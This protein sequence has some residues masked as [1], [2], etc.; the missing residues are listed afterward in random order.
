MSLV[1]LFDTLAFDGWNPLSIF[2]T[3]AASGADAWLASDTSAFA[4]TQIETRETPDAYVFSARLPPGVAKEELSIK[5]EVDEDGAGNGNVLVI[6]GERSVRREAVRG[7][8]RRQ[9]VIERSRATFFGRFHLPEDA[10]VDRVRAA[11]D[12][13]AGALLT[14]TVPRVG[15]VAAAA[16]D[17]VV[18]PEA[19]A[20]AVA[21]ETSPC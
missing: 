1:R 9:H 4:D 2:G 19:A 5:V 17:A 11:M 3:A 21:V 7:D 14:V 20:K 10:A 18:V 16:P 12:A 15:A 6:A 13:D 8:A